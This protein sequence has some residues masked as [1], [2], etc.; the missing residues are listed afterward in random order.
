MIGITPFY[1]TAC[2]K[3]WLRETLHALY[4]VVPR[5]DLA[6]FPGSTSQP[7]AFHIVLETVEPGNE[8]R[9]DPSRRNLEA[10]ALAHGF[11][12]R[13]YMR[14]RRSRERIRLPLKEGNSAPVAVPGR[15]KSE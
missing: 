1:L 4:I 7:S 8:A 6:S 5:S 11:I 10:H 12:D 13:V 14:R 9:S 3:A 2:R 15:C